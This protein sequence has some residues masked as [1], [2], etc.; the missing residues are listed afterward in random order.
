[1]I[2][3]NIESIYN[4]YVVNKLKTYKQFNEGLFDFLKKKKESKPIVMVNIDELEKLVEDILQPLKDDDIKYDLSLATL[5][6]PEKYNNGKHMKC[7]WEYNGREYRDAIVARFDYK[8]SDTILYEFLRNKQD[9]I[10]VYGL[11]CFYDEQKVRF[12]PGGPKPRDPETCY[13]VFSYKN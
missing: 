3:D 12:V 13:L 11:R 1:M 6:K 5:I 2:V 10:D 8:D 4:I 9:I 7:D